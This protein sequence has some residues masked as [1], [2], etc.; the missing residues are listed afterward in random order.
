M[1]TLSTLFRMLGKKASLRYPVRYL[2]TIQK[3]LHPLFHHLYV[4]LFYAT[5]VILC[6]NN[7]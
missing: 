4:I 1:S 2:F 6:P 3:A 7:I 5:G